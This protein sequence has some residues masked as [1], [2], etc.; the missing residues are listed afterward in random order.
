MA[1]DQIHLPFTCD[2]PIKA[3]PSVSFDGNVMVIDDTNE[4]TG[5]A[6]GLVRAYVDL[7]AG[8]S[9][10][11]RLVVEA[12]D[13]PLKVSIGGEMGDNHAQAGDFPQRINAGPH[14]HI[15][16]KFDPF[17]VARIPLLLVQPAA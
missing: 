2:D 15:G 9:Y 8:A 14:G 17:T 10:D 11:T 16:I 7:I 6:G 13:H 3:H 4:D 1:L 5:Q 12:T